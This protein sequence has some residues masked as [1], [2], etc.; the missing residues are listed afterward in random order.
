MLRFTCR[1]LKR[2]FGEFRGLTEFS[3]VMTDFA[4][5]KPSVVM[6]FFP[7]DVVPEAYCAHRGRLYFTLRFGLE[8]HLSISEALKQADNMS[9]TELIGNIEPFLEPHCKSDLPAQKRILDCWFKFI[10]ALYPKYH[11]LRLLNRFRWLIMKRILE[12]I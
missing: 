4:K 6:K 11:E 3:R 8:D 1:D 7:F 9:P 2:D 5:Y 10:L 12:G